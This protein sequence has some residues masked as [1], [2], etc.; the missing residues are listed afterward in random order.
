MPANTV[1]YS[2]VIR[3]RL[4]CLEYLE[5]QAL[6][7]AEITLVTSAAAA[8]Q[9]P[10]DLV[11]RLD[12]GLDLPLQ[13]G[14]SA[15]SD[16]RAEYDAV[17]IPNPDKI[18]ANPETPDYFSICDRVSAEHVRTWRDLYALILPLLQPLPIGYAYET[19]ALD[20]RGMMSDRYITVLCDREDAHLPV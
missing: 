19:D 13:E 8:D 11:S 6:T 14:V 12:A 7:P 9:L 10:A 3:T 4:H 18:A 15:P 1:T 17:M 16:V 2:D 20:L 5:G